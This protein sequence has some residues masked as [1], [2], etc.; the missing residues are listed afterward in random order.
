MTVCGVERSREAKG[1]ETRGHEGP[2]RPGTQKQPLKVDLG[3]GIRWGDPGVLRFIK[4]GDEDSRAGPGPGKE[5]PRARVGGQRTPGWG[6]H[7]SGLGAHRETPKRGQGFSRGLREWGRGPTEGR[8][9]GPRPERLGG[10]REGPAPRARE[11]SR[12]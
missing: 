6:G 3:R 10:Y 12:L 1:L 11:T 5:P 7:Q 4:P 8:R 9:G 2:G